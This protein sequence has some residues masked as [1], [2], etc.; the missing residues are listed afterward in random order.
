MA[1][2]GMNSLPFLVPYVMA[3]AAIKSPWSGS[4]PFWKVCLW[5]ACVLGW[6]T[7]LAAGRRALFLVVLSTPPLIFLP[8]LFLPGEEKA[9]GKRRVI[10]FTALLALAVTLI[11]VVLALI[12]EV[13][14]GAVWEQ[15]T[16]GFDLSAQTQDGDAVERRQQLIALSRGW[17]ERPLFGAGLGASVLGSI[18]SET[19]PWAY[20]L[21]YLALLYQTG[22]VG[23]LAY[24]AGVTWIFWRGL[25]IV[26]EGGRGAQLMI[27][28]LVGFSGLLIAN[29]TN[30]YLGKF[31]EMWT[32]FLPLAV[33]NRRLLRA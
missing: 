29:A 14:R 22:L 8:V 12:Y 10:K 15:F 30:P 11:F 20:E 1:I 21:Y 27:P 6:V 31:D 5:A 24:A 28:M 2:V 23:F 7:I 16:N 33:I 13:D 32:L 3:S 18:R 25:A 26:R 4:G 9:A 19:T 17:L